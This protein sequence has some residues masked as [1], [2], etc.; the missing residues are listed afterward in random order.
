MAFKLTQEG[1]DFPVLICDICGERIIDL[2]SDLVSGSRTTGNVVIHHR[3]CPTTE[4]VHTTI[5]KFFGMFLALNRVGDLASDGVV[6]KI[7]LESLVDERFE[8]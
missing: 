3:A 4:P 5:I 8:E 1:R 6:E 2:W 7:S